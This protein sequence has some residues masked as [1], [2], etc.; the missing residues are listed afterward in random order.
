MMPGLT[1][2]IVSRPRFQNFNPAF[3]PS[4][5]IQPCPSSSSFEQNI[6]PNTDSSTDPNILYKLL[7]FTS[8]ERDI[9]NQVNTSDLFLLK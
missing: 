5:E 6:I 1:P 2:V 7:L 3:A 9:Q 4:A 8:P